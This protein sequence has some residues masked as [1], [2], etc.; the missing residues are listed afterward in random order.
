VTA[1]V[2]G[3]PEASVDE[4]RLPSVPA[5]GPAPAQHTIPPQRGEGP[6]PSSPLGLGR[7]GWVSA[8]ARVR[9][10]LVRERV[11]IA[12]GSLAYHGFL[13]LFPA[14]IALLGV[15]TLTRLDG[16]EIT[17]IINGVDKALPPGAS[18]VFTTAVKAADK[19]KTG[20]TVAVVL[21]TATA[22]W[23]SSSAMAALQQAL[24]MAYEVPVDRKFLSR[25]LNGLPL[26]VATIILGGLGASLVVFGAS[27]GSG[28]E[29]MVPLKGFG[30]DI[31]WTVGRWLVTLLAVTALFAFFYYQGP[32]R[33][34]PK[35]QWVSAG[36]L[37]STVVFVVASVGFSFYVTEFGSYGRTYGSF[38]GVAVLVFWMYLTA[39]AVLVGGEV[40]AELEREAAIQAGHQGA[41]ASAQE[42]VSSSRPLAAHR[43]RPGS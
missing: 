24:D 2:P 4:A 5:T 20:S 40:N 13:A 33:E 42:L 11:S 19:R 30:F 8:L 21:G 3:H 16:S 26:M 37:V 29:G 10:K 15:I 34:R 43:R 23:S 32:N 17:H 35:W 12:A 25:R 39:L 38:A 14:V 1:P 7:T 6:G 27:I 18:D 9:A 31:I 28:I 36:G 41:M 22:V